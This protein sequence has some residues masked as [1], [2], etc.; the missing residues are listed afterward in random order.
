MSY[1]VQ[2]GDTIFDVA[3][4]VSGGIR[5]VDELLDLNDYTSYTPTLIPGEI[6]NTDG[7]TIYNNDTI[8]RAQQY[9]Y[10]SA[11]ISLDYLN[12]LIENLINEITVYINLYPNAIFLGED[13]NNNTN[14][15]VS[16][17]INWEVK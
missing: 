6:I 5:A 13:N 12:N 16:S 8:I 15:N 9:P 7:I 2:N 10:S 11:S 17:N 14:I 3:L 1:K 4:N